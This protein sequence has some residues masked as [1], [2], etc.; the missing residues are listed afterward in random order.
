MLHIVSKQRGN[1]SGGAFTIEDEGPYCEKGKPWG[2]K[3]A[4]LCCWGLFSVLVL[5]RMD[6]YITPEWGVKSAVEEMIKE[7]FLYYSLKWKY[8]RLLLVTK[9]YL[10]VFGRW[11]GLQIEDVNNNLIQTRFSKLLQLLSCL[12]TYLIIGKKI[13]CHRFASRSWTELIKDARSQ[14]SLLSQIKIYGTKQN[15]KLHIKTFPFYIT[16]STIMPS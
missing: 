8:V 14:F 4:L 2:L 5:M 11:C 1:D 13:P 12:Q 16:F 15:W 9:M 7:T 6:G 10:N 3:G